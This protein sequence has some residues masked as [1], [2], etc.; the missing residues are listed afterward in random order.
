MKVKSSKFGQSF[1][2]L[3]SDLFKAVPVRCRGFAVL[4]AGTPL[5][6]AGAAALDGTGAAGILL[7][8]VDPAENP[9]GAMVVQGVVDYA[10]AKA[11]AGITATAAFLQALMPDI[12]FRTNIGA[13]EEEEMAKIL[14][15][16]FTVQETEEGVSIT[17][18]ADFSEVR[19]AIDDDLA[20]IGKIAVAN[21]DVIFFAPLAAVSGTQ[22]DGAMA[23]SF[24]QNMADDGDLPKPA[25]QTIFFT[26]NGC[27]FESVELAVNQ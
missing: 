15:V 4:K 3:A 25:L 7:Y 14:Y 26:A 5:T 10:K 20:V 13:N 21:A 23:F 16:P 9:N 11:N 6:S 2:I 18:D 17:T 27:A 24:L 19:Q 8:D 22:E 12:C 1:A